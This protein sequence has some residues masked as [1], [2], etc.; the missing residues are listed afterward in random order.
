VALDP[1]AE[2][3][4]DAVE[5]LVDGLGEVVARSGKAPAEPIRARID[6]TGPPRVFTL[7][8]KRN[9]PTRRWR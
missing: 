1:A 5:L 3:S 2:V 4:S 9:G 6:T 8:T 7:V